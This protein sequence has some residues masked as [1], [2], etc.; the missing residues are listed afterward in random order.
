V[1]ETGKVTKV[2]IKKGT[3]TDKRGFALVLDPEAQFGRVTYRLVVGGKIVATETVT[4]LGPVLGEEWT[5]LQGQRSG[6]ISR[7]DS[8][9]RWARPIVILDQDGRDWPYRQGINFPAGSSEPV[10]AADLQLRG[11]FTMTIL[12]PDIEYERALRQVMQE[13]VPLLL[14][15]PCHRYIED[16]IFFVTNLA[17]RRLSS[18]TTVLVIQGQE[19]ALDPDSDFWL[20]SDPPPRWTYADLETQRTYQTNEDLLAVDSYFDLMYTVVL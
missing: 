15:T 9:Y 18:R 17:S 10:V 19:V 7:V 12:C 14:R 8:P 20:P 1:D 5:T 16:R 4:F 3:T 6:L 13:P 11:N 2:R